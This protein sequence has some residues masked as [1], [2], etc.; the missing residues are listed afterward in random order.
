MN[1]ERREK[2]KGQIKIINN[3]QIK[4]KTEKAILVH[5]T[6]Q[7]ERRS[8]TKEYST[9]KWIPKSQIATKNEAQ[10]AVPHW[11]ADEFFNAEEL[12]YPVEEYAKAIITGKIQNGDDFQF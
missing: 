2:M 5:Q 11:I 12:R 6:I 7:I 1:K 8:G 4:K 3:C 9:E 10:I